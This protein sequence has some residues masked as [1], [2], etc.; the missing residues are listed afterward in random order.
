MTDGPWVWEF[1]FFEIIFSS[2]F[3]IDDPET[4][5]WIGCVVCKSTKDCVQQIKKTEMLCWEM[6]EVILKNN[7]SF[8][9]FCSIRNQQIRRPEYKVTFHFRMRSVAKTVTALKLKMS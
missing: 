6:F 3:S 8:L 2:V 7:I 1:T 5:N 4:V 9:N